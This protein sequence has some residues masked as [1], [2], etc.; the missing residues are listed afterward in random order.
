MAMAIA[1]GLAFATVLTLIVTPCALLARANL[2]AW[3]RRRFSRRS[4][5]SD[6]PELPLDLPKAAE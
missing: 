3:L 4:K 2:A 6:Q 1:F 5:R